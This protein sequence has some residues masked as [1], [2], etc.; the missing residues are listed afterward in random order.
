MAYIPY[1]YDIPVIKDTVNYADHLLKSYALTAAALS[2]A[3]AV[4]LTLYKTAGEPV[5]ARL[6]GQVSVSM[7]PKVSVTPC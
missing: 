2:R 4:A 5:Q 6:Q 3:E 7:H 1:S